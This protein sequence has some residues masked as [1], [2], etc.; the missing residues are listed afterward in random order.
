MS[1]HAQSVSLKSTRLGGVSKV[2]AD[3]LHRLVSFGPWHAP[4]LPDDLHDDLGLGEPLP[5]DRAE[6]FWDAKRGSQARDLP[7]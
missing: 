5:F 6:A 2:L 7:L 1:A 4:K 3:L